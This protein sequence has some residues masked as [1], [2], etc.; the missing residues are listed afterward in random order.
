VDHR[1]RPGRRS[2]R[3]DFPASVGVVD[4]RW[5]RVPPLIQRPLVAFDSAA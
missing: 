4:S 1:G 2:G 3:D 5:S